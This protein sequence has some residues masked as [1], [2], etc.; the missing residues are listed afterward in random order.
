MLLSKIHPYVFIAHENFQVGHNYLFVN[1]FY[2][3]KIFLDLQFGVKDFYKD[4]LEK[5]FKRLQAILVYVQE[6]T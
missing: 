5:T 6:Y 3:L 4:V 1:Q 2:T